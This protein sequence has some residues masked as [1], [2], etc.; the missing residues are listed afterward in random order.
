[1]R[2]SKEHAIYAMSKENKA[3]LRCQSGD[4]VVFE[5]CDCFHDTVRHEADV[6]SSV[7]FDRVNPATG[8]LY[9]EGADVDDLLKVDILSITVDT[10]GAVVAAPG[11]GRLA[12][13]IEKEQTAIG[14]I[15]GDKVVILGRELPVNKMIGV[16]GTA[17]DGE[18][19]ST[20]TPHDHGGNMD[21]AEVREGVS[22]YLPVCVEGALLAMG[23]L[24]ACMGDGEVMG[25]GLE[26][27]GEV[28]V[29]VEVVK[30]NTPYALY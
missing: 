17:P 4:T 27:A 18:A 11:L 29:R 24:H 26:V 9:I 21:C 8:P 10:Q 12:D 7:D 5:T 13:L 25:C 20:G 19:I 23:D 3:V 1:M 28:T 2:I 16:I 6:V 15:S 14:K 22:L 30:E